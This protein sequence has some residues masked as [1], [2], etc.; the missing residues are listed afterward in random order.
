LSSTAHGHQQ[1]SFV[2][3]AA[4][5][6]SATVVTLSNVMLL[7]HP[8]RINGGEGRPRRPKDG[9]ANKSQGRDFTV[10]GAGFN[11]AQV[12]S[13]WD[14]SHTVNVVDRIQSTC[15]PTATGCNNASGK[16]RPG[17]TDMS[18]LPDDLH[19]RSLVVMTTVTTDVTRAAAAAEIAVGTSIRHRA[20]GLH[21]ATA[22]PTDTQVHNAQKM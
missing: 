8:G 7:K 13:R 15:A 4:S 22:T 14:G 3:Y 18:P 17:A 21:T 2:P 19:Q 5:A 6:I 9:N 11:Y 10:A 20:G 16:L 12:W 1:H